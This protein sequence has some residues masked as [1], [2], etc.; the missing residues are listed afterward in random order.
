LNDQSY[1]NT[2]LLIKIPTLCKDSVKWVHLS[3]L[4]LFPFCMNVCK[5]KIRFDGTCFESLLIELGLQIIKISLM[6]IIYYHYDQCMKFKKIQVKINTKSS[7]NFYYVRF[8]QI[9]LIIYLIMNRHEIKIVTI[10]YY[11]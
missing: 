5:Y 11:A 10:M 1:L 4:H 7:N 9:A 3:P 6:Y 8:I 2:S